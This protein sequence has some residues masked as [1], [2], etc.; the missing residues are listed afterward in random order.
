[1]DARII[2][3]GRSPDF[4]RSM[5]RGTEL[6][7]LQNT[8]QQQNALA[9]LYNTQGPGIAAGDP[10]AL[11]A[12]ARMDP[13][14]AQGMRIRQEDQAYQQQARAESLAM[15]RERLQ[16]AR[17][18]AKRA[19][20]EYARTLT[21]E[22]RAAQAAEIEQGLAGAAPLYKAGD[23]NGY[24]AW[25]QSQG[26]DPAQY[27]FEQFPSL[28]ASLM[29]LAEAMKAPEPADEYGRYVA[30]ET[31]AGRQPLSRL[32]YKRAGSP[33]TR[34]ET[35]PDGRTT[36]VQGVGA[37]SAPAFTES[38]S[39]DNVYVTRAEGA[40][41]LLDPVAG[42]LTNRTETVLG[43]VPLGIGRE[44]QTDTFQVAKQAG[45]E[46]LQAILRKDT[47]AAITE[48]EQALYGETYLPRPGDGAAVLEAKRQARVRAVEAM[49]A[50]MSVAQITAT[51]KALVEA[52]RR[53]GTAP[54]AI[55]D[56]EALMRQLL[57]GN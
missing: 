42:A 14:A 26:M 16:M 43:A 37:G 31:A 55:T 20:E 57:E 10:N 2:L 53:S 39:K 21:A 29:G 30:E 54:E 28:A 56:D 23:R 46:F 24:N 12:L 47:G 4:A 7:S 27:P 51:E 38:Q 22:Q 40:L 25:L 1:M 5:A 19:G 3:A 15:E 48:Q 33:S 32:D 36:V 50:G 34:I 44:A 45:D 52:A 8:V 9:A 17:D 41:A 11:N 6:A 49:R 18:A 35:G 13:M